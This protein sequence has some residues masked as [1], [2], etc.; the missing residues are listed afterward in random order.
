MAAV[1]SP[2]GAAGD[3]QWKEVAGDD[4]RRDLGA[5]RGLD[6]VSIERTGPG[7]TGVGEHGAVN[8]VDEERPRA[9][10]ALRTGDRNPVVGIEEGDVPAGEGVGGEAAQ[11]AGR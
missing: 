10:A 9:V 8:G 5:D 11:Q 3:R 7:V 6:R 4:A 2:R 1:V